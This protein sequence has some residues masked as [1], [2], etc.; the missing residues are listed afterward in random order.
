MN[1]AHRFGLE[2]NGGQVFEHHSRCQHWQFLQ[3]HV[4]VLASC[5]PVIDCNDES[6]RNDVRVDD[7]G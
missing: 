6:A 7:F 5:I 4:D 2:K 3:C 1:A